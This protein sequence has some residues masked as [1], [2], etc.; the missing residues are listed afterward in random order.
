MES[1]TDVGE[2]VGPYVRMREI[3]NIRVITLARPE[4]ANALVQELIDGVRECV[5]RISEDEDARAVV[6][7]ALGPNFS[8]GGDVA[9]FAAHEGPDLAA[10]ARDMVGSLN[11]M[12]IDLMRLP[13]PVV[14]A[15]RGAIT[16]G[17]LGFL[18]ASDVVLLA[19]GAFVAPYY[20]DVGFSPDGGWTAILP[21]RIG[22]TRAAMV[23]FANE[24]I[25]VQRALAWG[26]AA[27]VADDVE[28]TA[29]EMA[30]HFASKKREAVVRTKLLLRDDL[31]Q[32]EGR[33]D[34]ELANFVEQIQTEEARVGMNDFLGRQGATR[35]EG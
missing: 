27:D 4:R 6:L 30:Q 10:Y 33:L 16:G 32:L 9:A 2:S 13:I 8:T 18:L 28:E 23:Q 31:T 7:T 15:A 25:D 1:Y 12:I 3:G 34:A 19:P 24:S 35:G 17:S 29:T 11:G 14:T 21:Q 22:R 26:L 5:I 20:V